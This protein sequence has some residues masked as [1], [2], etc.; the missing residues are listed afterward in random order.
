MRSGLLLYIFLYAAS[1][2]FPQDAASFKTV[3]NFRGFDWGASMEEIKAGETSRYMQR[4]TG[5]GVDALSFE[6]EFCGIKS[7]IDFSFRDNKLAE[8]SYCINPGSSFHEKFNHLK[9]CLIRRHGK[10]RYAAGNEF[11]SDSLWIKQNNVGLFLGPSIYWVFANGFLM[12]HS[13]KFEDEITITILYAH[14]KTI[15]EYDEDL[16][17]PVD[18][19]REF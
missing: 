15:S 5:F 10:P 9:K 16:P 3:N 13:S 17:A 12:L 4:F 11:N 2:A 19:F 6:G 1:A 18:E 14:G 8:G 7:R